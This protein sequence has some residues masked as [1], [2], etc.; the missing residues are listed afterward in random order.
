MVGGEKLP[1]LPPTIH[2]I[3]TADCR[4][5]VAVQKATAGIHPKEVYQVEGG[6]TL[7]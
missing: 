5:P 6:C 1:E 7:S 2:H 3:L 4:R